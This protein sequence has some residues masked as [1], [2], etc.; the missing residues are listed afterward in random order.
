M[1][2]P[3]PVLN[4]LKRRAADISARTPSKVIGVEYLTRWHVLPKNPLF[5]VYLHHVQGND[6]DTHL[7]DHP[8]LFNCSI[9]LRGEI[10]E[11]LPKR[12]RVLKEGT[13]TGRMS[14]A[15]HRLDLRSNDSLTLFLTGPKIRRWGFYTEKGWVDSD[16][17]L[18]QG[19]D[20]R[21]VNTQYLS[22]NAAER[23][24]N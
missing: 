10:D 18:R 8:W 4:F 22:D 20:G 7:H 23:I 6:P 1:K 13:V 16:Q 2:L 17:Y 21:A 3:L 15:P 24:T 12:H 9:V 5:N 19:G 11:T 14:R